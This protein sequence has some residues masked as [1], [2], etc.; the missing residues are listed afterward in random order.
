M[1]IF[2]SEDIRKIEEATIKEQGI[3]R[4]ELIER[5]AVAVTYEIE[6]RL[7]ATSKLIFF[8]GPT[9]NGAQ[10]LAI[11]RMLHNDGFSQMVVCLFNIGGNCL[12]PECEHNKKELL[13]LGDISFQE[14]TYSFTPPAIE[15]TDIVIDGL[16]GAELSAPL[17]RG[18]DSVVRYINENSQFTISLDC[19]SGLLSEWNY[20]SVRN[21]IICAK[22]TYANQFTHLSFYFRENAE[23]IGEVKILDLEYSKS[24]IKLMQTQYNLVRNKEVR[25]T[26]HKRNAFANKYDYGHL[27][28]IAGSYG[29]A[30]AAIMA[31]R[32]ALRSGCGVV[33][34]HTP[35]SCYTPLQCAVP[36]VMVDAD[37]GD[38][39]I[40]NL[41][42]INT[43][44]T[45][46]AIVVGPGLRRLEDTVNALEQ[47][48]VRQCKVPCVL[49]ADA[50]NCVSDYPA[51]L[52]RLPEL[53]VLTPNNA[54]F[55]RLFGKCFTDEAR[56]TRAIEESSKRNI[57]IVIKGHYTMVVRP[58]GRVFVNS[59]GNAGM[60]TAGSGDA[61][62]GI[63]GAL[64]AQKYT[65][66]VA[67][68]LA[69]YIHGYAG[70]L[71]AKEHG[72][73]GMITSDLIDNI[74]IAIKEI[75]S[76]K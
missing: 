63:I 12:S 29:M 53:C 40:N 43:G 1:K 16:F 31:S 60:A 45:L 57:I 30:G 21:N 70:D 9:E 22:L 17:T 33:T 44:R 35:R 59:T 26:L 47:F 65:P 56:L 55:D 67:A 14:I 41:A 7:K 64:L 46:S 49:D 6:G 52:D 73:Y 72:K 5:A 19:P 2:S 13:E 61:L 38:I 58:D 20:K 3:T 66:E 62:A 50:L 15:E 24:A 42:N 69:V 68:V 54:E 74:G 8:A 48:L 11:A 51:L 71:S 75:M 39:I 25:M 23:F 4:L 37:D 18:Y 34:V 36:E 76:S 27:M 10:A 28:I 32:A